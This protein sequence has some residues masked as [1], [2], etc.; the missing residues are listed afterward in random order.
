MAER[1]QSDAEIIAASLDTPEEFGRIFERHHRAVF[2]FVAK[3][4]PSRDDAADLTT[5]IFLRAFSIRRRYDRTR[6]E[7]LPWLYGIAHN[8]IGDRLRRSKRDER[9][10]LTAGDIERGRDPSEDSDSRTVAQQASARLNAALAKLSRKD[11]ETLLLYALEGL[12]YQEISRVL[13]IPVGTVGSRISRAR[14]RILELI[15]DLEQIVR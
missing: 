6:P 12:T 10:Y 9:V 7:C 2:R 3:R 4:R 15:P 1:H 5:E 13:D 11:R 8:V 14:H